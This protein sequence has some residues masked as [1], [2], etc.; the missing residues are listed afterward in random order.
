MIR[1]SE[2]VKSYIESSPYLNDAII[3]GLINLSALAREIQPVISMEIHKEISHSS[4]LMALKRYSEKVVLH[5]KARLG[6]NK[7][8]GEISITSNLTALTVDVNELVYKHIIEL[9][10]IINHQG[11]KF[12]TFTKGDTQ[13]TFITSDIN[14]ELLKEVLKQ[15]EI[16][17]RNE[18]VK[19]CALTINLKDNHLATPGI[20]AHVLNSLA[21]KGVNVVEVV[22]T[23]DTLTV[24]LAD[25][26]IEKGFAIVKNLMRQ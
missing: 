1:I 22:S 23:A 8:L 7:H 4:L 12:S 19:L 9:L 20:I 5:K 6:L 21:W 26:D 17:V 10:T 11:G 13:I 16:Q 2:R 15:K 14:T 24:L 3:G 25:E 18:D